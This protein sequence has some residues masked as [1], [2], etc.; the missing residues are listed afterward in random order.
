MEIQRIIK[1]ARAYR[2][3]SGLN[4]RQ[5]A[6][7]VGFKSDNTLSNM[8]SKDWNPTRKTLEA[9]ADFLPNDW[10][11]GDPIPNEDERAA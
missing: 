4:P 10:A 7:V 2:K 11:P 3:Q 5:F 6:R 8:D 9:L 1:F